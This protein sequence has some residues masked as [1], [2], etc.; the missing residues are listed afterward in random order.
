MTYADDDKAIKLEITLSEQQNC[1]SARDDDDDVDI[2]C[3]AHI[4][5]HYGYDCKHW[6]Y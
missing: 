5:T 3:I 1:S 6:I 2:D 4:Y